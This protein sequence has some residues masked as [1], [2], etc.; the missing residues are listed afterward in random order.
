MLVLFSLLIN[1]LKVLKLL[2]PVVSALSP[3][4]HVDPQINSSPWLY[5]AFYRLS[6][7]RFSFMAHDFPVSVASRSAHQPDFTAAAG[8]CSDKPAPESINK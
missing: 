5:G 4:E 1:R 8:S 6:A 2:W 3:A 7:Y